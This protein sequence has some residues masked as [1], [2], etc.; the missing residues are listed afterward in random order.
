MSTSNKLSKERNQKQ[1]LELASL[2]GNNICADCKA[3]N[4]RW[5]SH[6]LG[7]F[8]CMHCASI[9]RSIGT[10]ITKV[11]SLTMDDW[12]REQV[13]NMENIGNI[14]SNAIYN[15]NELKYPP[16]PNLEDSERDSEIEQYIRS[17]YQYKKFYD[18]A[19]LVASK[20]GPSRSATS[21]TNSRSS[22]L[23]SSASSPTAVRASTSRPSTA[24]GAPAPAAIAQRSVSSQVPSAPNG[25]SSTPATPA[26]PATTQPIRASTVQSGGVWDDLNGLSRP[27]QNSSLPLQYQAPSFSPS[28][29][30]APMMNGVTSYTT[31][32]PGMG[33]NP[34][35]PQQILMNSF[36][37]SM[38]G[39]SI[40]STQS[41]PTFVAQSQFGQQLMA[42][43]MPQQQQQNQLMGQPT[44]GSFFQPQ[45]QNLQMQVPQQ[46]Q[47][48]LTPSPSQPFMSNQMHQTNFLT[49]SP[50]QQFVSHSP[51]LQ[52][53]GMMFQN[54]GAATP[55]PGQNGFLGMTT[56]QMQQ[57][58]MVQQQQMQQ[59]QQQQQ[60]Q[61]MYGT[62]Q[63][64]PQMMGSMNM[65]GGG[66]TYA[67]GQQWGAF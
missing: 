36:S 26:R 50:S 65:F 5:A 6:N 25:S 34:Y 12:T 53:S 13:E 64:Q 46:Q 67:Q 14:K 30:Q 20:L 7:I 42:G 33:T 9:H 37:P 2:H 58:Q 29:L 19:A 18:R 44:S 66:Q 38:T 21:I 23:P 24:S 41:L 35:Q 43:N 40:S 32:M 22:T 55:Q 52:Q 62:S 61:N 28:P 11:K 49:P 8:I 51:Q 47:G 39:S 4:P 16:P 48:F 15:P 45:P 1:L 31:G 57:Q 10:H 17:K 3:R 60:M 54:Q 56:M 59:Q 27:G 63:M